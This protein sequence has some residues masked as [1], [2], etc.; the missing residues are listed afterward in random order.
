MTSDLGGDPPSWRIR[1]PRPREPNFG[2]IIDVHTRRAAATGTDVR[3][4]WTFDP[5]LRWVQVVVPPC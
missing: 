5:I 3:M 4:I 2:E 1:N